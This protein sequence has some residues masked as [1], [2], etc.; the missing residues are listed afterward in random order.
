MPVGTDRQTDR[1]TARFSIVASQ[2]LATN[3]SFKAFRNFCL[4][5]RSNTTM[6]VTNEIFHDPLVSHSGNFVMSLFWRRLSSLTLR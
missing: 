5:K 6:T 2:E 3:Q 1:Q 4:P